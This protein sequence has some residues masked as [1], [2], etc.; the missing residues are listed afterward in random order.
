MK[1]KHDYNWIIHIF[2]I[3]FFLA[4]F[5]S[6]VS[7]ITI[8]N[9]NIVGSLLVLLGIVFLGIVFDIIGIAVAAANVKPFNAM[10]SRKIKGANKAVSLVQKADRVSN[11]CNDVIGDIAGILSGAAIAAIALK[12]IQYDYSFFNVSIVA[13][14]LSGFT[15]ALTVGGKAF[16]K[17]IAIRKWKDI[18]FYTAYTL[19]IIETKIKLKVMR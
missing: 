5:I 16:G 12:L 15:A 19:Y 17:K 13:V 18:V 3:T 2:F 4:V 14:L 8:K 9:F 1:R 7:E 10:A 6:I 11:F